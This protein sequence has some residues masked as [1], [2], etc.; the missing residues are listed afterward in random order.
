ME[1][2]LETYHELE[3]DI[4]STDILRGDATD[5]GLNGSKVEEWLNS[6][7][8]GKKCRY[9]SLEEPREREGYRG[10]QIFIIQRV[11]RVDRRTRCTG[12]PGDFHQSERARAGG[13]MFVSS[14]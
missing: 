3:K 13:M 8:G 11:H 12:I 7:L 14:W 10:F 5:A 2:L 1:K 6:G 9:G 4:S